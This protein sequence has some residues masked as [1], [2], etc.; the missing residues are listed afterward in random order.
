MAKKINFLTVDE[1][2]RASAALRDL[3]IEHV[4]VQYPKW[5]YE[6]GD[7]RTPKQD[8]IT[9]YYLV[10]LNRLLNDAKAA[11]SE[12]KLTPKKIKN[13]RHYE[14]LTVKHQHYQPK[15]TCKCR[16]CAKEFTSAVKEAMWCS[17]KCKQNFRNTKKKE[18]V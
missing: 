1:T 16:H 8:E 3:H 10:V 18:A 12:A 9:A 13:A 15:F 17:P 7:A 11:F 5:V 2:K 4:V 14:A 6:H